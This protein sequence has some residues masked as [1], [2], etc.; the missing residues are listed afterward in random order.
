MRDPR[1]TGGMTKDRLHGILWTLAIAVAFYLAI[2]GGH[3][4]I[5]R[6]TLEADQQAVRSAYEHGRL[7]R[8]QAI[9]NG[10]S[11]TDPAFSE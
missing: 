9:E 10:L 3:A 4:W 7:T 5:G 6:L 2:L 1:Y 8:E 11:P